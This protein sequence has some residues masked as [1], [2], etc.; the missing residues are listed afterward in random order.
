M[1]VERDFEAFRRCHRHPGNVAFHVMCGWACLSL[2]FSLVGVPWLVPYALAVGWWFRR[3]AIAALV[4]VAS[5]GL[6][7]WAIDAAAWP[8]GPRAAGVIGFYFLPEVSHL[9]CREPPVLSVASITPGG[10]LLNF[11]VFLPSS[12]ACVSRSPGASDRSQTSPVATTHA[13][14]TPVAAAVSAPPATLAPASAQTPAPSG[15]A[16]E[17][18]NSRG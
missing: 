5:V 17:T 7:A 6:G 8:V 18:T 10:L 4:A 1:N 2:F 9:V 16:A 11:L 13:P 14:I 3:H 15:S 12:L